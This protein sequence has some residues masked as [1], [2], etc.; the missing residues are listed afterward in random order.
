MNKL[1]KYTQT[2]L[3]NCLLMTF[4]FF[5]LFNTPAFAD[6]TSSMEDLQSR[7]RS[8][9]TPLAIIFLVIAGMQKAMGNN[10]IFV[11]ALVGTIIM[12]GA[13]QIV[14]FISAAFGG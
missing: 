3:F 4:L 10:Q 6:L 8:I 14:S 5:I 1:K 2:Y 9:C 7:V 12:F 13:P 11:L